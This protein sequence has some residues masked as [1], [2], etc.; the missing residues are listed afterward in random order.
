[1]ANRRMFSKVITNSSRFLMMPLS[2]QCLYFHLGM[3]SDDD[4]FCEHFGIMRMTESKPDDLKIL[5]AKEFV[6]IFDDKV[7]VILDWKEN[8]YLRSDRYTPSKYLEVYKN[9]LA[10]ISQGKDSGIPEVYQMATQSKVSKGK[11][12]TGGEPPEVYSYEKELQ[13][14]IDS[15][16]IDMKVIGLYF[17]N[18]NY[19]FDNKEQFNSAIT[20]NLKSAKLLKG[21][22]GKQVQDTM[23]YCKEELGV[24]NIPWTLETVVKRIADIAN[25]K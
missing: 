21:Y 10:L 18:Q 25:K 14:L 3:N 12:N 16:R 9:E 6:K 24:K 5:H 2:A 22:S 20:R 11:D 7:L 13:K 4:G 19:K 17:K 15:S 23:T 8:N 1:M